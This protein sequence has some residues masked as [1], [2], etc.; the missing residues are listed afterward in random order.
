MSADDEFDTH[1]LTRRTFLTRASAASTVLCGGLLVPVGVATVE[2]RE[3]PQSQN[4][5]WD[6][7]WVDKLNGPHRVVFDSPEIAEGAALMQHSSVLLGYHEV[8]GANTPLQAVIV[9]RSVGVRMAFNNAIW[10]KYKL[11]DEL[12]LPGNGNP[13]TSQ[14][15]RLNDQGV[16]LLACNLAATYYARQMARQA[17]L[18]PDAV[19][20]EVRS[21][22]APGVILMP[23]GVFAVARAQEAGCQMIVSS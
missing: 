20:E 17:G 5:K 6:M 1:A 12:K 2:N 15:S 9:M 22:L 23:S 11:N 14:I 8:Y 18:Q 19:V 3:L 7:A 16:T 10:Q 13:Y 21:N 4:P